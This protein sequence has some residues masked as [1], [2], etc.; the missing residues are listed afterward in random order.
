LNEVKVAVVT[1]ADNGNGRSAARALAAA[2][3]QV[4]VNGPGG[5]VED[6]VSEINGAGG[7]AVASHDPVND[8]ASCARVVDYA[9]SCFGRVDIVAPCATRL[10]PAELFELTEADIDE[11][12]AVHVKGHLGLIKAALPHMRAQGSGRV[13]T[14]GS[15]AAFQANAPLPYVA[16]MAAIL[17]LTSELAT[18]LRPDGITV[19]CVMPG[20]RTAD[21][22]AGE[23]ELI[24]GIPAANDLDPDGIGPVVVYL[25]SDSAQGIT[26]RY[27]YAADGLVAVFRHPLSTVDRD[28]VARTPGQWTPDGLDEVLEAFLDVNS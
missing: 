10:T 20:T 6:V 13:I 12:M 3:V 1:G 17:G 28:V 16:S 7:A 11:S 4:V 18:Q 19:N 14:F 8:F 27:L 15:Y 26:G 24:A 5:R 2:G 21:S 9:V 23:S 25:A 22:P